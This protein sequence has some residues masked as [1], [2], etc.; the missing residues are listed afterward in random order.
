ME[1]RLIISVRGSWMC[2]GAQHLG[3]S[4]PLCSARAAT[5]QRFSGSQLD[6]SVNSKPLYNGVGMVHVR[7]G[8]FLFWNRLDGMLRCFRA[9][10]TLEGDITSSSG[11]IE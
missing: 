1:G 10:L 6:P 2:S 7:A 5:T 4:L 8:K 3:L 11:I 9:D